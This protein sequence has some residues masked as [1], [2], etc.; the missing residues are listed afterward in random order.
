MSPL[1]KKN[2]LIRLLSG[3]A[4]VVVVVGSLL[5]SPYLMLALLLTITLGAMVEFY[6]L[7]QKSGATPQEFLPMLMGA[8][9]VVLAFFTK[10]QFVSPWF[11]AALL[12]LMALL[13]IT[14][15]YRKSERPFENLGWSVLGILYIALPMALLAYL[16]VQPAAGG[17]V[18]YRPM[19]L[20]NVILIVWANDVGAYMVGSLIGRR[21]LMERISPLKSWEGLFGG[22]I[23]AVGVGVLLAHFQGS[24][25]W[26][27]SGGALLI[28][29]GAVYGD[30]VESMFKR[31]IHTKDSGD[32]IPGH[33]GFLDRFDALLLA[34][35]LIFVYLLI[36]A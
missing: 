16:P 22:L 21:R 1:R 29:V 24:P 17:Y 33:G 25:W 6:K 18:I 28:A 5:L 23:S 36:F 27:W 2:F 14:E 4:L 3:L 9:L 34:A 8:L 31:S 15:L 30:L 26:L 32:L 11:F 19:M 13:F 7:A 10:L 20:L 35:P 12:P